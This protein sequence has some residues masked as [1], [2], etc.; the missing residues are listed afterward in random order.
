MNHKFT[1]GKH[2]YVPA[3]K[4]GFTAFYNAEKDGRFKYVDSTDKPVVAIVR[5]PVPRLVSFF[6]DKAWN[7]NPRSIPT[8]WLMRGF[9]FKNADQL[10]TLKF[11]D[12]VSWLASVP[13]EQWDIHVKV[14]SKTGFFDGLTIGHMVDIDVHS[15]W[16]FE[17]VGID[18]I[19]GVFYNKSRGNIIPTQQE[20]EAINR[21]YAEDIEWMERYREVWGVPKQK[22]QPD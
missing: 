9:G 8:Q 1:D 21:L 10:K 15:D 17:L 3:L 12:F 4:C 18:P 2:V 7:P 11:S 16:V 6:K 14:F 22:H 5:Q 20:Q 13:C 19:D